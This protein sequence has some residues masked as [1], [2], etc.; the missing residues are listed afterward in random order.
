M[1][2]REQPVNFP[3]DVKGGIRTADFVG[4][5]LVLFQLAGMGGEVTD[6]REGLGDGGRINSGVMIN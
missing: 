1:G 2:L 6:R 4:G 3:G 5:D